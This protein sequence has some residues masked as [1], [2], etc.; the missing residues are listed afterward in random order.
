[1][2]QLIVKS[3]QL[4]DVQPCPNA[5]ANMTSEAARRSESRS[6]I[7][8]DCKTL[9]RS[10]ANNVLTRPTYDVPRA[11]F[12]NNHCTAVLRDSLL[13]VA[14]DLVLVDRE[15]RLAHSCPSRC[16]NGT[17][18]YDKRHLS[19]I[20]RLTIAFFVFLILGVTSC[21]HAE[22]SNSTAETSDAVTRKLFIDPSSTSVALGKASVLRQT[23]C[24]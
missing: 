24:P 2:L 11:N 10:S 20:M 8:R 9:L 7:H 19:Q 13:P 14:A 3:R 23:E 1:M 12:A 18:L 17:H 21:I 5:H 4:T 6:V 22:R 16:S 15:N